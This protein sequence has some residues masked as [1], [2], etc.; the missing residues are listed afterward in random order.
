MAPDKRVSKRKAAPVAADSPAKKTKKVE[1]KPAEATKEAAP[2]S[3]LKKNE[4]GTKSKTEKAAAP[5]KTNGEP[6]RQVKPRKRAADFLTDEEAE[7]SVAP[8]QAEKKAEKKP[9]AKKSKK[10]EAEPAPAPKKAA[11]KKAGPKSKKPEPVVESEEEDA[12]ANVSPADDSDSE[13]EGDDQTE[14]LIKGFESSGDEDESDGEGYKE[15]EPIPKAPDTKKAERKL[16]K[17]LRKNGPPEEPGTVYLGRIPHGFY[18]HQMKAYFSQ[19]GE[20]TKLRLSRNRLT[21]RSK[22]YAFI[23]FSSTT[24][25]KIVADTMDNYLMYG[26]IVKCK[27]VPKEQLHPEIWK[28]ANRRFKVTPW[29]LIEKKRLAKGKTREQWS[30]SIESEQKK[31]QAKINKLKA[32]GYELD[33]PQLK[34]VDD[35]PIQE[36]PKA[37]EAAEAIEITEAAS[38]EAVKAVEAPAAIEA[39]APTDDTPKKTKK[40]K[41][42]ETPKAATTESPAAKSTVTKTK[43]KVTKKATKTKSKA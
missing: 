43:G 15:G 18:E 16:A 34:C 19:F 38:E 42:T 1:A 39:P 22:H 21:G 9:A 13:N 6:T 31:R 33:L 14:A 10:E 37:V 32:L 35:V 23:E 8:V 12:E 28:G 17:Q 26:H 29:N 30:K 20:I 7:D 11:A 3:I 36:A 41:K 40:G 24:V 2:K 5:A 4:K 27:F 25:A